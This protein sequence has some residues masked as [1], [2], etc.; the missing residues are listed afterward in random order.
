MFGG[1]TNFVVFRQIHELNDP[2]KGWQ[3]AKQKLK[4]LGIELELDTTEIQ[5]VK[6]L[7]TPPSLFRSSC[8]SVW[9]NFTNNH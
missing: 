2:N 5:Q 8:S 7:I 1:I 6:V 4:A 3:K 9:F